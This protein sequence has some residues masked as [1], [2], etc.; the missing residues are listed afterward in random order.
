MSG[1]ETTYLRIQVRLFS[2]IRYRIGKD[3][4]EIVLPPGST[5]EHAEQRVRTMLG[6]G[7]RD[8]VFRMACNCEFVV[9]PLALSDGDEVAILPP[10]QGG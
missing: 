1:A 7:G 5:T 8:A 4:L 10:M 3:Q 9:E 6:Q 2:D